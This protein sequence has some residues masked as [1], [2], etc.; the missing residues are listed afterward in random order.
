MAYDVYAPHSPVALALKMYIVH[1]PRL[2][3][4]PEDIVALVSK[5]KK[6]KREMMLAVHLMPNLRAHYVQQVGI[7]GRQ[8][9]VFSPHDITWQTLKLKSAGVVLVHNH[10]FE[11]NLK[12]TKQDIAVTAR[13]YKACRAVHSNLVDHIIIGPDGHLSMAEKGI[14]YKHPHPRYSLKVE[15]L[16]VKKAVLLCSRQALVKTFVGRRGDDQ[17]ALQD[18]V[19]SLDII[20]T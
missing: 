13:M 14:C 10:P 7:G 19:Y 3:A 6:L 9:V 2:I 12:A 11:E 8:S 1:P 5:Y 20:A 17:L 4:G 15:D 18:G 16:K